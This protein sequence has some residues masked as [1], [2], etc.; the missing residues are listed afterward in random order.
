MKTIKQSALEQRPDLASASLSRV[1]SLRSPSRNRTLSGS[2]AKPLLAFLLF[3]SASYNT[4]ADEAANATRLAQSRIEAA[5]FPC[6]TVHSAMLTNRMVSVNGFLV[7]KYAGFDKAGWVSIDCDA[8]HHRYAID[9]V[10][11]DWRVRD[12][13]PNETAEVAALKRE[14]SKRG[15]PCDRVKQVWHGNAVTGVQCRVETQ[16]MMTRFGMSGTT[17]RT[18]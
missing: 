10:N 4:Q 11:G 18:T 7:Q 15:L 2:L 6:T 14:I 1:Q 12:V 8:G 9:Q 16:R 5:G 17:A 3:L 13:S